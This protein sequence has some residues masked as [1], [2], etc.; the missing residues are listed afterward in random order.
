MLTGAAK[1]AGGGVQPAEPAFVGVMQMGETT[2]SVPEPVRHPLCGKNAAG[3]S[4]LAAD[5][6]VL[7]SEDALH[8]TL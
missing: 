4:T 7:I 2:M 3:T 1:M 6:I 5:C 8:A